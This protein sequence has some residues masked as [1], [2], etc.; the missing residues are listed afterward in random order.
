MDQYL[1]GDEATS[2]HVEASE[3]ASSR[4]GEVVLTKRQA[5]LGKLET[6]RFTA[7]RMESEITNNKLN[8]KILK[9][10]R[11]LLLHP[12]FIRA[13]DFLELMPK[14]LILNSWR[15]LTLLKIIYH[16]LGFKKTLY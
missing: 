2:S 13:L 12:Y 11:M 1:E 14:Q 8:E 9:A 5:W 3:E 6:S 16:Q 15:I 7:C 4:S 10:G